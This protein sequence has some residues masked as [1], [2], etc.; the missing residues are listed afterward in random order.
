MHLK[1]TAVE[2]IE[3]DEHRNE[4]NCHLVVGI[5]PE[6]CQLLPSDSDQWPVQMSGWTRAN[7]LARRLF[8]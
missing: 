7:N 6:H 1:R 2:V 3:K 4:A 8:V 5:C